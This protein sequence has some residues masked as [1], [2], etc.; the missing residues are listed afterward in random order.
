MILRR[1]VLDMKKMFS[2]LFP[3]EKDRKQST[4][5]SIGVFCLI[6]G[7]AVQIVIIICSFFWT[8]DQFGLPNVVPYIYIVFT[9][10]SL[11]PYGNYVIF[12]LNLLLFI[13]IFKGPNIFLHP[14]FYHVV[15]MA[16]YVLGNT[17]LNNLPKEKVPVR[18]GKD[19]MEYND[20][21]QFTIAHEEVSD[22]R[23]MTLKKTWKTNTKYFF[24]NIIRP[25]S[26]MQSFSI[27]CPVCGKELV[28]ADVWSVET[29]KSQNVKFR[30]R[31][32]S[33]A[34]LIPVFVLCDIFLF[35]NKMVPQSSRLFAVLLVFFSLAALISLVVL[36]ASFAGLADSKSP[37][38]SF[39]TAKGELQNE[40]LGGPNNQH[41]I[42]KVEGS[43]SAQVKT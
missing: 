19:G 39:G 25:Q 12:A 4:A 41:Y 37:N 42:K 35:K 1:V 9:L 21:L 10:L 20:G 3:A 17:I 2:S 36:L 40:R 8:E 27:D 15:G 28:I 5:C 16:L 7:L 6:S 34:I 26:G 22:I 33:S 32:K 14:T 31:L 29:I 11:A 38:C 24:Y 13:S 30:K 43:C 18:K 23:D